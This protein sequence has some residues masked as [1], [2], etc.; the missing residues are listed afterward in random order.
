M[1]RNI[2]F[3]L[4]LM[5]SAG[6]VMAETPLEERQ[7]QNKLSRTSSNIYKLPVKA[8]VTY[9]LQTAVGYISTI[10]LPEEAL[11]VFVGDAELFKVEVY[12][13]QV[14]VKPATDYQEARTN[15]TVYIP[16]GR[17]TF[18]VSVGTPETADFV[19]DFRLSAPEALVQNE[20]KSKL[21]EKKKQLETQ[22]QE[23]EKKQAESVK[24]MALEK[25]EE[26]IK[27]GAATKSL[28]LS[29]KANGIQLNLLSLSQI[30]ETNYL[31]FSILNYSERDFEIERMVLG[32]ETV[33]WQ[34]LSFRREGFVPVDVSLNVE[35]KIPKN[36]Y[37][38]GLLGFGKVALQKNE[39]L[40]LRL[41]E[42]GGNSLIQIDSLPAEAK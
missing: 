40:V 3:F 41:Y 23:K 42:K 39:R 29:E 37:H 11:K 38:Y 21:D 19:L 34:G 17:L 31:R 15:L 32:K 5:L 16:S 18:D 27:K 9:R 10:D 13:P 36:S 22:Y 12:G 26:E 33:R 14:I 4:V 24:Q 2:A 7:K 25:L 35:N 8:G 30:G 1:F 28:K 20:F 6:T